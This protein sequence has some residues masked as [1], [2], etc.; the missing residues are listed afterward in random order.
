M[1]PSSTQYV[2]RDGRA[3]AYQVVGAGPADM[4]FFLEANLHLDLMWTDPQIHYL[5][6]RVA[7]FGRAVFFQRRGLGLSDPIDYIPTLEQQADDVLAVMDAVGMERATL[8]GVAS[9]CGAISLVAARSPARVTG[10]ILVQPFAESVLSSNPHGW[11]PA[12]RDKFVAG[13]RDAYTRWGSGQSAAMWDPDVESPYNRRVMGMLERCS[14]TPATAKAHFEWLMRLDYSQALPSIQCPAR[15]LLPQAS[16]LARG[17]AEYVAELIPHGSFHL[18]P[19]TPPGASLGEAWLPILDHV[20]EVA[21]GAHRSGDADRFLAALLFTDLVGS[22]A[23]LAKMGDRAYSE[24]R[25]AHE[26]HVRREVEQAGG[27]L[28]NVTGDGTFSI[29]EGPAAAVSCA[30]RICEGARELGIE[31]R[32]GVH[33]G[34][35]QQAGPELTGMT[36][37]VGARIGAAAGPG[38]VLVSRPVRDLVVGSGLVFTDRGEQ[39]L[40]GVPGKWRLYALART[41][42]APPAVPEESPALGVGDRALLRLARRHPWV[43]RAGVGVGN[44]VQRR[45]NR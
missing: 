18:L 3:L 37:H 8:V 38:E 14:A 22:T 13:W 11:D 39:Q 7:S 6:E 5:F 31:A 43:L 29:F 40:K 30:L 44:A 35:V 20:E 33:M 12:E 32:A 36:V 16:S 42:A 19:P 23:A 34:E 28:V 45:L 24:L 2:E 1:D 21:T 41:G 10:L 17:A 9:T 26:R 15:V 25:A 4:V 27:R